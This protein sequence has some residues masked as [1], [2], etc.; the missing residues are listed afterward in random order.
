MIKPN[1]I[2]KATTAQQINHLTVDTTATNVQIT[3]PTATR[4]RTN[5]LEMIALDL[6]HVIAPT[7]NHA[8]RAA[9]AA[10]IT[11]M[12]HTS[13]MTKRSTKTYTMH[14]TRTRRTTQDITRL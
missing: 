3:T 10:I 4:I 7:P 5:D 6:T 1:I 2:N 11:E 9:Q 13:T 8:V 14:F 12:V